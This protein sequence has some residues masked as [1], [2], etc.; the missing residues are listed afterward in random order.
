MKIIE[1]NQ[2]E[3]I[4]LMRDIADAKAEGRRFRLAIDDDEIKWKIGEDCWTVGAG[5][6]DPD[7]GYARRQEE[8]AMTALRNDLDNERYFSQ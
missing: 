2:A 4:E 5:R 6:L 1:L 8:A 3:Q 7:S